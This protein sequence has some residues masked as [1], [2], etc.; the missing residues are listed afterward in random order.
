[1]YENIYCYFNNL[2][3]HKFNND[4][5]TFYINKEYYFRKNKSL[6]IRTINYPYQIL[7]KIKYCFPDLAIFI[8]KIGVFND[9]EELYKNMDN[10]NI[11]IINKK[12]YL[13]AENLSK[14]Y[15][16]IELIDKYKTLSEYSYDTLNSINDV[17][18]LQNMEQEKFRKL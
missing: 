17:K 8:E 15:Y 5:N 3:E 18:Y 12:I 16:L 4:L 6:I 9:L 10:F 2:L 13:V 7:E 1:M 14:L 11:I